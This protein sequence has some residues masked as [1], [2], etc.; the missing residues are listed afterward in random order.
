MPL[1]KAEKIVLYRSLDDQATF[2]KATES[3]SSSI[4]I[5]DTDTTYEVVAYGAGGAPS[6]P[7]QL[8]VK[9]DK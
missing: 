6:M 1:C 8:G 4:K 2:V 5:P 3:R 9:S 7:L